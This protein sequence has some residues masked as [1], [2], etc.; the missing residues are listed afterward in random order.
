[1]YGGTFLSQ[2][3]V[4]LWKYEH[5]LEH[6]NNERRKVLESI[7]E[8]SIDIPSLFYCQISIIETNL[9]KCIYRS[10]TTTVGY[11]WHKYIFEEYMILHKLPIWFYI[12][13][14]VPKLN[15]LPSQI[16]LELSRDTRHGSP[17]CWPNR[18]ALFIHTYQ[19]WNSNCDFENTL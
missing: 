10:A 4:P 1:M 8:R 18:S 9:V 17:L 11:C 19:T 7:V 2:R 16:L 12:V 6:N 3:S 14:P 13:F 15:V 5:I